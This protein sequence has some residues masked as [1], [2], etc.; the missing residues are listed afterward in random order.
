[1]NKVSKFILLVNT[2]LTASLEAMNFGCPVIVHSG[3][4]FQKITGESYLKQDPSKIHLICDKMITLDHRSFVDHGTT[5]LDEG[6]HSD[7]VG[8]NSPL[9]L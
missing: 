2:A 1:M 9:V 6:F 4:A 3:R 7:K 8:L 5:V